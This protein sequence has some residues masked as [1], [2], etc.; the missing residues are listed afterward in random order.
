M[1]PCKWRT[2]GQV[3]GGGR[4]EFRLSFFFPFFFF[5]FFLLFFFLL[6]MSLAYI[7]TVYDFSFHNKLFTLFSIPPIKY[8]QTNETLAFPHSPTASPDPHHY[9]QASCKC[10]KVIYSTTSSVLN[11][12]QDISSQKNVIYCFLQD[13]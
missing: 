10:M 13:G 1:Q 12:F 9:E 3:L 7:I 2:G 5:F 8:Q 11:K 6:P 4:K